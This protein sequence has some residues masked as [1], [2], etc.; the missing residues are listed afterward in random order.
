MA[1]RLQTTTLRTA[2]VTAIDGA[3]AAERADDCCDAF[4][5]DIGATWSL[6]LARNGTDVA[7]L[8]Y[9]SAWT[10]SAADTLVPPAAPN[11]VSIGSADINTGTW[12]ARVVVSGQSRLTTDSVG[13]ES[14]GAD[15]T[16]SQNLAGDA[17]VTLGGAISWP[18]EVP[19]APTDPIDAGDILFE[20][21]PELTLQAQPSHIGY[22]TCGTNHSSRGLTTATLTNTTTTVDSIRRLA[23]SS[24]RLG[25]QADP[26]DSSRQVLYVAQEDN[27][28]VI[29][30]PR[31][32]LNYYRAI[33]EGDPSVGTD[34]FWVAW[35]YRFLSSSW[36]TGTNLYGVI[37][38]QLHQFGANT[39]PALNPWLAL[40]AE[41]GVLR[42]IVRTSSAETTTTSTTSVADAANIGSVGPL[43]VWQTF[44][45]KGRRR[46]TTGMTAG[47][48]T[49]WRNGVQ[50]YSWDGLTGYNGGTPTPKVGIY[51]LASSL[52]HSLLMGRYV[53][54]GD[55]AQ[56]YTESDL[57][58]HVEN[59]RG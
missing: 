22:E 24:L 53:V 29:S 58:A 44:V 39:G 51:P 31:T 55:A 3:V 7:T 28:E 8:N 50:I 5:A 56:A 21:D 18:F 20:F 32:E 54:V 27:D 45:V 1:W 36:T 11:T 43:N 52:D 42:I 23:T 41:R 19:P 15:V 33:T 2:I 46:W 57:R 59:W 34:W 26:A 47:G 13:P 37:M 49:L 38:M 14:S 16:I 12:A 40:S 10:K 35:R 6:I 9:T 4:I 30:Q 48:I 17:S 25:R